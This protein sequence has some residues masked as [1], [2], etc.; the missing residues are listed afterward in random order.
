[1]QIIKN[2]YKVGGSLEGLTWN[3]CYG[4][5]TDS[6]V[7]VLKTSEGLI[8]FDCGTS[9]LFNQVISNMEYWGLNIEDVRACF[10]THS[11]I[12]HAGACHKLAELGI[13]IYAH[14]DAAEAIALGDDRC[15]GYLYHK[16]FHPTTSVIPLE[17]GDVVEICGIRIDCKNYPGHSMGCM[18]YF[19]EFEE[20]RIAVSGDVIG[21][22]LDGY[23][24]WAGSI[25]FNKCKYLDSLKRFSKENFDI[26]LPG[27]GMVYFNKPRVRIEDALNMGLIEWR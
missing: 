23:H 25:D 1:M 8:L 6:N 7:F 15:C 2:I 20:R 9:E 5:Y 21:T 19:F 3:G 26:M 24:G 10:I 18:V 14:S 13:K 12:D 11:H 4:S 27:H 22:L 17:D 16:V